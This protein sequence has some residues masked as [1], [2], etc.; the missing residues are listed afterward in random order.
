MTTPTLGRADLIPLFLP[1]I[2]PPPPLCQSPGPAYPKSAQPE[3]EGLRVEMSHVTGDKMHNETDTTAKNN[4][5][6]GEFTRDLN[7]SVA[8]GL[9]KDNL[10]SNS[11]SRAPINASKLR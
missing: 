5:Y 9:T 10:L 6:T 4:I 1:L 7:A 2:P 11:D 3:G 8:A